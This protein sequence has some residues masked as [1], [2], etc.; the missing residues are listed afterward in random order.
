MSEGLARTCCQ[1]APGVDAL[2]TNG[3]LVNT[4]DLTRNLLGAKREVAEDAWPINHKGADAS[5]KDVLRRPELRC[6]S[7]APPANGRAARGGAACWG[8]GSERLYFF[9]LEFASPDRSAPWS[10]M[11]K[12]CEVRGVS[13]VR[14]NV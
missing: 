14:A 4:F 3:C 12:R 1:S 7:G 2:P 10:Q 6:Q 8:I 11:P 5:R 13:S 9:V